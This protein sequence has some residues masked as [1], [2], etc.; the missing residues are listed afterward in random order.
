MSNSLW[1]RGLY[2]ARLLRPWHFPGKNTGVCCHFLLQ[3]ILLTQRSNPCFLHWQVNPLPLTEPH[4]KPT[5]GIVIRNCTSPGPIRL[6]A[7]GPIHPHSPSMSQDTVQKGL[8]SPLPAVRKMGHFFGT[9]GCDLPEA[10]ASN[11]KNWWDFKGRF[12]PWSCAKHNLHI[13][14]WSLSFLAMVTLD[15][16]GRV[17][18]CPEYN[19]E[20]GN[21]RSI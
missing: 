13:C 1:P 4:K 14:T 12:I 11:Y 20:E 9:L 8:A 18:W 3:W 17:Q 2:P 6:E 5:V 10:W 16:Q 7:G 19:V 21:Y 15:H